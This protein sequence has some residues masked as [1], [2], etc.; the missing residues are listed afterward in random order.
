MRV[1]AGNKTHTSVSQGADT[2][3]D[4]DPDVSG[5]D[6]D[7][8]GIEELDHAADDSLEKIEELS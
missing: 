1:W 8:P 2:D 4:H 3:Q 6:M 5:E 7:P